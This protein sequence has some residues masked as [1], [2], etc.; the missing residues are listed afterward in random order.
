[1]CLLVVGFLFYCSWECMVVGALP[2]GCCVGVIQ[3]CAS[4]VICGSLVVIVGSL[5]GWYG[6][7]IG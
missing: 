1:M 5:D 3:G 4:I 2:I 6:R 7:V